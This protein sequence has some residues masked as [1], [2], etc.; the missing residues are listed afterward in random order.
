MINIVKMAILP[1][2]AY[3]FNAILIQI[4]TQLFTDMEESFSVASRPAAHKD[5]VHL[6]G[7]LE[8][9][10]RETRQLR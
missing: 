7:S 1:K 5:G 6:S 8:L 2:L 3:R 10:E 9:K 4:P